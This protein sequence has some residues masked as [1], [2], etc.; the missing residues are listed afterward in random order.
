M[1]QKPDYEMDDEDLA[2][3]LVALRYWQQAL[4]DAANGSPHN[5]LPRYQDCGYFDNVEPLDPEAIDDLCER[6]NFA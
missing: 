3:I 5:P 4:T 2:T 1:A 6:I